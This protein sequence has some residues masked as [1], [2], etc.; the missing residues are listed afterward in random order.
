M[1]PADVSSSNRS[2]MA[3]TT[4][5]KEGTDLTAHPKAKHSRTGSV[6]SPKTVPVPLPPEHHPDEELEEKCPLF[7]LITTYLSYLI[8][9]VIGHVRDFFGKRFKPR[10]YEHLQHQN[11]HTAEIKRFQ[12]LNRAMHLSTVISSPSIRAKSIC[13]LGIAGTVRLLASQDGLYGCWNGLVQTATRLSSKLSNDHHH[14]K[15]S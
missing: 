6:N 11:V 12:S 4:T 7:I 5:K 9:T 1:S 15:L 2:R 3:M 13:A 8:L 14:T 10:Q